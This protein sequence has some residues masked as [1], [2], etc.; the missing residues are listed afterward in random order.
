MIAGPE[1][2]HQLQLAGATG[3]DDVRISAHRRI[4]RVDAAVDQRIRPRAGD[5]GDLRGLEVGRRGG[6]RARDLDEREVVRTVGPRALRAEEEREPVADVV[7]GHQQVGE[8]AGQARLAEEARERGVEPCVVIAL[9]DPA[10]DRED[11][12]QQAAVEDPRALLDVDA[13][14]LL[15]RVQRPAVGR[16]PGQPAGE[17]AAGRRAGDEVDELRDLVPGAPLD[18]RQHERRDQAAD[19]AAVDAEDLHARESSFRRATG[20]RG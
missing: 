3:G 2:E 4:D 20:A 10:L 5:V 11:P 19:A 9:V 16:R 1:R 6:G 17:D 15:G 8:R 14:E 7:G 13:G 18:L 12:P